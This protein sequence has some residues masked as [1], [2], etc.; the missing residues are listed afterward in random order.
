MA[1]REEW[2]KL[3]S[4]FERSGLSHAEFAEARGIQRHGLRSWLYRLRSE[5]RSPK[6]RLLPVRVRNR[7]N[8]IPTDQAAGSV[9]EIQIP[10]ATLHVTEGTSVEYVAAL[11]RALRDGC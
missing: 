4:D 10:N 6:M 8:D 3:V 11:V 5:R 2:V 9:V 7:A 1:S